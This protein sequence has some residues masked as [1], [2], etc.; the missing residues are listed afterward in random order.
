MDIIERK[1]LVGIHPGIIQV[2]IKIF[3]TIQWKYIKNY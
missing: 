2:L 3:L 1:H